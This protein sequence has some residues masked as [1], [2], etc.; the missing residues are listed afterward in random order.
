MP[1][2][3]F[4]AP[5][6]ST[7]LPATIVI[8]SLPNKHCKIS[9]WILV[10]AEKNPDMIYT[11]GPW[12][13]WFCGHHWNFE[14]VWYGPL[15]NGY[16]RRLSQNLKKRKNKTLLQEA[17]PTRIPPFSYILGRWD[18]W[19]GNGSTR[20]LRRAWMFTTRPPVHPVAACYCSHQKILSFQW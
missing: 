10:M 14:H 8:V 3:W 4:N 20:W 7:L 11:R 6:V 16:Q 1:Q 13:F 2:I 9:G 18:A 12:A 19:R 17:K 15:Q 5:E